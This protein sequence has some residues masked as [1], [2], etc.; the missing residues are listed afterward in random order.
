VQSAGYVSE[1]FVSF[2]GEGLHAGR[3]QL[4]LRMGGCHLRCR[5]CDTPDSLE[6]A[7]AYR[8]FR[9][10][11]VLEEAN[12]VGPE[13]LA[14]SIDHV[15]R[16]AGRV[17]GT[18]ITGGE[19]LLQAEF[20]NRFLTDSPW[21]PRPVLLETSGTLPERLLTIVSQI[22][23]VSM[24]IKIP[25][26]TAE[27]PFWEEHQRFLHLASGKAYVKVLFDDATNPDEVEIAARLVAQNSVET[28]FFLQPITGKAGRVA[29]EQP[30]IDRFFD[31]ARRHLAD[32]RVLPQ[33]HKMLR[34]R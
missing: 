11:T 9:N 13:R 32:V 22:D 1:I 3:R 31:R 21:L 34:I 7:P 26:N 6:R 17:D 19:P 14:A 25:S 18:A 12:P 2:Q 30:N 29:I 24:D 8:S 20:L 28:P 15:L 16:A 27:R 5:Y 33:T 10:G 4:F 23:I